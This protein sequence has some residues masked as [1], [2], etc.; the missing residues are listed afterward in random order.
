MCAPL[1]D[2]LLRIL[3][4]H[5]TPTR[6]RRRAEIIVGLNGFSSGLREAA[7]KLGR[8]VKTVGV[9][10]RRAA[11]WNAE[12][13]ERLEQALGEA[14]HAGPETRTIRLARELLQDEPRPGRPPIYSPQQYAEIMAIAV[15]E[16]GNSGRPITQW[17]ARELADEVRRRKIC[18]ASPRQV[19]RYLNDVDLQPHRSR[20]WLNPKLEKGHDAR[21]AAVCG[22]YAMA[23]TN[24]DGTHIVSVDEKTSIQ[25]NERI[26]PDKPMRPGDPAKLEAEYVRHGTLCLIPSFD[27]VTGRIVG[28]RIGETRD[29][30]DFALHIAQTIADDPEAKWIFVLD[31]L[32]T[33]ASE[34][35]VRLVAD[36]IG[37]LG[38]LGTKNKRGIV[39]NVATRKEFLENPEHRIR[40]VYTPKHCSWLNQ[41]EIWFGI[42]ARKLLRRGTFCSKEDLRQRMEQFIDYFNRTMAKPYKWTYQG[43]TLRV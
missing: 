23:G 1:L 2:A 43:K 30:Q 29:E 5:T 34:T 4:M 19:G 24:P 8:D 35:L 27:V 9:W 13:Q 10:Y 3:A 18:G 26:H 40:F 33:H 42:L 20:Y 41:V 31:Q 37:H 15:S 22:V 7:A 6:E 16:P 11:R 28:Y 17:T 32:N 14:G 38:D 21:V 39:Q 36:H 25:A 12:F